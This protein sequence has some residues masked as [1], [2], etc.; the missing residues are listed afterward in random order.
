MHA[1]LLHS[2]APTEL[3]AMASFRAKYTLSR[4]FAE[5]LLKTH[6]GS[7]EGGQW[8]SD[9]MEVVLVHYLALVRSLAATTS[10]LNKKMFS[11]AVEKVLGAGPR[12]SAGFAETMRDCLA[13]CW[14]NRHQGS[15]CVCSRESHIHI[16]SRRPLGARGLLD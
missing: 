1:A 6:V 8:K 2:L 5:E 9:D 4:A 13:F 7:L 12:A 11:A 3:C 15:A 16:A 14:G 10:R